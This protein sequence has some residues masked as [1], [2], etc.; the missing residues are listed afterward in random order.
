VR[1]TVAR[2]DLETTKI[3]FTLAADFVPPPVSIGRKVEREPPARPRR[4]SRR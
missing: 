1:V 2:V 4:S 3:D